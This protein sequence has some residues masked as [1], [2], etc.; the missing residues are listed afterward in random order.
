M[1]L[2]A[3]EKTPMKAS[4]A[5]YVA[6]HFGGTV[7]TVLKGRKRLGYI[8]KRRNRAQNGRGCAYFLRKFVSALGCCLCSEK[9]AT[10]AAH[11]IAISDGGADTVENILP[12][13]PTHHVLFDRK[14]L[15]TEELSILQKYKENQLPQEREAFVR[16]K[17]LTFGKPKVGRKITISERA[18]NQRARKTT[19]LRF[20]ANLP[21]KDDLAYKWFEVTEI[22]LNEEL[23]KLENAENDFTPRGPYRSATISTS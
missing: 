2:E 13:C 7:F 12:F 11:E 16:A 20:L 3:E 15:T 1:F 21:A 9:R 17:A 22:E 10:E 5:E 8:W 18:A 14:L 19:V 6:K 4:R 23:R